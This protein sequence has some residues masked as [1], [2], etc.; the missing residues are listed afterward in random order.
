VLI[1]WIAVAAGCVPITETLV[2]AMHA[3]LLLQSEVPLATRVMAHV[4]STVV[5]PTAGP[6]RLFTKAEA[7][8]AGAFAMAFLRTVFV[9]E[10]PGL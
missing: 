6:Y 3:Q 10:D 5:A 9:Q 8:V 7:Q 2:V 1:F 4:V